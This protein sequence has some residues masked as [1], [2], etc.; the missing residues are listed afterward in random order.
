MYKVQQ[1][2]SELRFSVSNSSPQAAI[3][4]QVGFQVQSSTWHLGVSCDISIIPVLLNNKHRN[5]KGQHLAVTKAD[6][7]HAQEAY[8]WVQCGL[9]NC[10][11]CAVRALSCGAERMQRNLAHIIN[12]APTEGADCNQ[13]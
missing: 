6:W 1:R 9:A 2:Q 4:G 8:M 12:L 3:L 5:Q 10:Q 11:G 7:T 13:V